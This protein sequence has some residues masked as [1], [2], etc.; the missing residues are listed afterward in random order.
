MPLRLPVLC[1]ICIWNEDSNEDGNPAC[2]AFP[3]GIPDEMLTGEADHRSP[4]PD[5]RGVRFEEDPEANP[6]LVAA[7]YD[8]MDRL[9]RT[10]SIWDE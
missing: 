1:N 9:A 10:G 2:K 8:H 3:S 7:A 4:F 5:D 6:D